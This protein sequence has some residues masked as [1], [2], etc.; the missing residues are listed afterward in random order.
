MISQEMIDIN[1]DGYVDILMGYH[2]SMD[3]TT[4]SQQSNTHVYP[5][6]IQVMILMFTLR[7]MY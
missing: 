5:F 1:D 7:H 2:I 6:W 4:T 3:G